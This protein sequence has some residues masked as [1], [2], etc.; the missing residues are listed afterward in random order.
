MFI[1]K[2]RGFSLLELLIIVLIIS[3]LIAVAIPNFFDFQL[4]SKRAK[5]REDIDIIV[6]AISLFEQEEGKSLWEAA[7]YAE[8]AGMDFDLAIAGV[9]SVSDTN[10]LNMLVGP[11]LK[12]LPADPWGNRYVCDMEV[13]YV[14]SRGSDGEEYLLDTASEVDIKVYY[15]APTLQIKDAVYL[16]VANDGI[17][18]GDKLYIYFTQTVCFTGQDL[19]GL[20]A[21]GNDGQD[22][23]DDNATGNSTVV[24]AAAVVANMLETYDSVGANATDLVGVTQIASLDGLQDLLGGGTLADDLVDYDTRCLVIEID[25]GV[26]I[27]QGV[28]NLKN[29]GYLNLGAGI[30]AGTLTACDSAINP[31]AIPCPGFGVRVRKD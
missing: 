6:N 3:I 24:N 31:L 22:G 30:V 14:L 20:I 11:Y 27:D 17:A 7:A 15:N 29:N 26:E 9:D 4:R 18:E 2:N 28:L 10:V 13:G 19:A 25:T 5:A 21:N 12:S 1:K 8:D 16:D 23:L